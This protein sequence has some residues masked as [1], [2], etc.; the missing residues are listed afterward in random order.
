MEN[1]PAINANGSANNNGTSNIIATTAINIPAKKQL[2]ISM[3][4]YFTGFF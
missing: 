3:V 2:N 4:S 1:A